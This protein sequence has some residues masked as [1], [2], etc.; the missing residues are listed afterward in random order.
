MI[1]KPTVTIKYDTAVYLWE[2]EPNSVICDLLHLD[3]ARSF[4]P[5]NVI[6]QEDSGYDICVPKP[7][8]NG[9][10]LINEN[11]LKTMKATQLKAFHA[12]TQG[13]GRTTK[14]DKE[15][16]IQDI[17]QHH[18]IAL[19]QNGTPS[20]KAKK[21]PSVQGM[22][23]ELLYKTTSNLSLVDFYTEQYHLIDRMNK[24]YYTHSTN[25]VPN[26]I[27]FFQ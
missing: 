20:T 24:Y 3:P 7:M 2:N 10:I 13:C 18:S 25:K 6:I 5:A 22:T 19:K 27:L 21:K 23:D 4:E 17:L 12:K 14:K 1:T 11:T 16:L 15:E 26:T 9:K 8:E